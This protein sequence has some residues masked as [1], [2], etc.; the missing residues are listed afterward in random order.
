MFNRIF[1]LFKIARKL[2]TSGAIDTI[3]QIYNLPIAINIFFNFISIGSQ[4]K[5]LNN[6][7]QPGEKLCV[8][9]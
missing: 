7:K 4:R 9:D 2:S 8:R 3:N 6:E 1:Q 5:I